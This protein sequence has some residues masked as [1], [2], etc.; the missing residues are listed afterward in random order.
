MKPYDPDKYFKENFKA[1]SYSP[2]IINKFKEVSEFISKHTAMNKDKIELWLMKHYDDMQ[3][4][5]LP[6]VFGKYV[7]WKDFA[8]YFLHDKRIP[9]L[10]EFRRLH[11]KRESKSLNEYLTKLIEAEDNLPMDEKEIVGL[12]KRLQNETFR[13]KAQRA[14]FAKIVFQ[15]ALSSN[16]KARKL[17]Y[18]VGSFISYYEN[19]GMISEDEWRKLNNTDN[20]MSESTTNKD[21]KIK[22]YDGFMFEEHGI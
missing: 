18:K 17:I 21:K 1:R 6:P 11:G 4:L 13:N 7:Q 15:L 22:P 8:N 2:L 10:R 9:T 14:E 19:D 12:I 20:I 16:P 5:E 3:I